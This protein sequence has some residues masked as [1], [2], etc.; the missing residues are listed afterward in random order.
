VWQLS[1]EQPQ[2]MAWAHDRPDCGGGF[3]FTGLHHHSNLANAGFRTVL[4]NALAWV[5][6]LEI[7]KGG[8]PSK[9]PSDTELK[10]VVVEAKTVR[11]EKY[12]VS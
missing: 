11:K 5:A 10:K 6:G 1:E 2:H 9:D 7:P 8:V 4:L 12:T 3:G